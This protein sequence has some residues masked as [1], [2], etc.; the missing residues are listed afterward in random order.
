MNVLFYLDQIDHK[1]II[2]HFGDLKIGCLMSHS[3]FGNMICVI[4]FY[5]TSENLVATCNI[6]MKINIIYDLQK[7]F[8]E[9]ENIKRFLLF[10][11]DLVF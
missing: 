2:N 3:N 1:N 6:I 9:I 10:Q 4:N 8:I 5:L 11:I 7:M